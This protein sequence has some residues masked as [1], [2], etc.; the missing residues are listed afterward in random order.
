MAR[1]QED[2]RVIPLV[3]PDC[4]TRLPAEGGSVIFPCAACGLLWE[5]R[6]GALVREEL[7]VLAGAGDFHLP[8]WLFPFQ[9]AEKNAIA[10]SLADYRGLTGAISP[11]EP[12]RQG[13]PPLAFV[14]AAAGMPPHLLLR[15]G[16]LLTL[17]SPAL[18]VTTGFPAR[19]KA[20]GLGERDAALM[21]PTVV[22]ATIGE[23]RRRNLSF[24]QTVAVSIGQ[25]RLCAIPFE[26]RGER[27]LHE[28]WSLE[29]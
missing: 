2:L 5:P 12:E 26:E 6:D 22:L 21:A 28:Q 14:P 18:M 25:G 3:C 20:I 7:H 29:I 24:L 16:R 23:E 10:T 27:L 9:V 8:C 11:L 4:G 1:E 19:L 15:A 13:T 17:R